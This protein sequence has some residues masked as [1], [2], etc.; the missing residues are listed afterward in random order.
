MSDDRVTGV[1]DWLSRASVHGIV[2]PLFWLPVSLAGCW[3][4]AMAVEDLVPIPGARWIGLGVGALVAWRLCFTGLWNLTLYPHRPKR[5][6]EGLLWATPLL[7]VA[8][9]AA[10]Y[11][12]P[13]WGWL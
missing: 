8:G 10:A 7:I 5:R 1:K 3:T 4:I 11:G 2:G 12:L 6:T 13:I 9:Y